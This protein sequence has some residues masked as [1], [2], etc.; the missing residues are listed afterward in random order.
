MSSGPI[1]LTRAHNPNTN[2]GFGAFFCIPPQFMRYG[3]SVGLDHRVWSQLDERLR[4]VNKVANLP[5]KKKKKGIK[6]RTWRPSSLAIGADARGFLLMEEEEEQK[7]AMRPCFSSNKRRKSRSGAPSFAPINNLD[8]GCLMHIFSF[9]SPIPGILF[10]SIPFR[11]LFCPNFRH[12][13]FVPH[14]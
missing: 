10:G 11:L 8:D 1:F 6:L 14:M 3:V 13:D 12:L 7:P 4:C 2:F 5:T 9:L